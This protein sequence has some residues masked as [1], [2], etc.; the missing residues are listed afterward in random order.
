MSAPRPPDAARLLA[1]ARA[2][3][4]TLDPFTDAWPGLD[5]AWAYA[6]QDADRDARLAAGARLV[7]AK[8]GLTSA[9]KQERM[10]VREPIVGFLTSD[11]VLG[12]TVDAAVLGQPRAESEPVL[13]TAVPLGAGGAVPATAGEVDAVVDAAAVGLEVIDS[14][15]TGYRFR[16]PDVVADATSAAG[17]AVGPW[18]ATDALDGGLAVLGDDEVALLVDG[19]EVDRAPQSAV[20]GDPRLA[21]VH[22]ARHLAARGETLPAGS[23]VL[24]GAVTDA[25]PL[26]PGG[27]VAARSALLGEVVLEVTS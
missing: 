14:R 1:E 6:V 18:V 7:G 24:A 11:L 2:G 4:R 3:R 27:T 17:F 23:V 10:G 25:V 20:L 16:L 15:F 22:L 13:R 5:A 8:L 12:A 21:V 9:A 26:P 19:A